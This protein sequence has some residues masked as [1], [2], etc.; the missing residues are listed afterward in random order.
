MDISGY[1]RG[2]RVGRAAHLTQSTWAYHSDPAGKRKRRKGLSTGARI[3]LLLLFLAAAWT[4]IRRAMRQEPAAATNGSNGGKAGSKAGGQ[5]GSRV[6]AKGGGKAAKG[7]ATKPAAKAPV[8]PAV[9]A[10]L[11]AALEARIE[12][13]MR[14]NPTYRGPG[15][16]G[17]RLL[18][19]AWPGY[20]AAPGRQERCTAGH[21]QLQPG[22]PTVSID[23]PS[24]P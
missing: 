1:Q 7:A 14:I 5:A 20:V 13:M 22:G 10:K 19:L 17:W 6:G 2:G 11:D 16:V 4:G 9:A 18:A 23:F 3:V 8:D 24:Q 15:K 12:R 21:L